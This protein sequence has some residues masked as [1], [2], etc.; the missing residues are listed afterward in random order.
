M[1]SKNNSVINHYKALRERVG[2]VV[3]SLKHN[4]LVFASKAKILF[5]VKTED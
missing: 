3:E 4:D 1:T 2:T 5:D